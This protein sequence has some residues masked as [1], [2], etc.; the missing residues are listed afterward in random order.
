[1]SGLREVLG[2]IPNVS[3]FFLTSGISADAAYQLIH[4]ELNLD[5]SSLLNFASFVHTWMP[6]Q[7]DKLMQENMNKN[8]IVAYLRHVRNHT[9]AERGL[10][11][12]KNG[13]AAQTLII[14]AQSNLENL[15]LDV[16]LELMLYLDW[17]E[18]I[19]LRQTSR[20]LDLATRERALWHTLVKNSSSRFLLRKRIQ[21]CSSQELEDAFLG[22]HKAERRWV[23]HGTPQRIRELGKLED[24]ADTNNFKI[25][26]GGRWLLRLDKTEELLYTDLDSD[27]RVWH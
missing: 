23:Q 19:Q 12:A 11:L 10:R 27:D 5:G 21:V 18:I 16:L 2:S 13:L 15:P 22:I 6:P 17:H 9:S 8:L 25:L 20:K 1:M 4:D 26:P 24:A 3:N 7:A 14:P